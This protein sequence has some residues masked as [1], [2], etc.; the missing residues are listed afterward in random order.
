MRLARLMTIAL[1][2]G[3]A[4]SLSGCDTFRKPRIGSGAF[5]DVVSGSIT[6]PGA[7]AREVV[8]QAR[9]VA[10]RIDAQNSYG[11]ANCPDWR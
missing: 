3:L 9:P 4:I 11:A 1:P 5:C 6:F 8:S 2:I 7:L 10:E